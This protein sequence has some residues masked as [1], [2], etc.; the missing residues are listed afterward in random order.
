MPG[1]YG[2]GTSSDH[3][4]LFGKAETEPGPI[5]CRCLHV[6]GSIL[7]TKGSPTPVP[8]AL[9]S[10]QFFSAPNQETFFSND[11]LSEYKCFTCIIF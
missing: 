2:T 6:G 4:S 3:K 11:S 5:T 7:R 1:L 9:A 10:D 8:D